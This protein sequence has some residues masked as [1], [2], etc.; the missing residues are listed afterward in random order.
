MP[1]DD[2]SE[3]PCASPELPPHV[4]Q[5]PIEE[6]ETGN[7]VDAE[8]EC[9]AESGMCMRTV[10]TPWNIIAMMAEYSLRQPSLYQLLKHSIHF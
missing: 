9:S 5:Q 6:E 3:D 1:S 7:S 10:L 2:L 8:E 4:Q